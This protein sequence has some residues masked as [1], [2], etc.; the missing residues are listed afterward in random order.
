VEEMWD[1]EKTFHL[2][3]DVDGVL[4]HSAAYLKGGLVSDWM[5]WQS[6]LAMTLL[7]FVLV[8]SVILSLALSMSQCKFESQKGNSVPIQ[9][10]STIYVPFLLLLYATT[11]TG[12]ITFF[13]AIV[14]CYTLESVTAAAQGK[15]ILFEVAGMIPLLVTSVLVAVATYCWANKAGLAPVETDEPNKDATKDADL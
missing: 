9:R 10:F 4:A 12:M 11:L 14:N 3:K 2:T 5:L 6:G 1:L 8:A 7:T 13:I 15:M